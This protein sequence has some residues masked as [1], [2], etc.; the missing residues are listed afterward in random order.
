MQEVLLSRIF[1]LSFLVPDGIIVAPDYS[2]TNT[3]EKTINHQIKEKLRHIWF[4]LGEQKIT[5]GFYRFIYNALTKVKYDIFAPK[6]N[7]YSSTR[8]DHWIVEYIFPGKF[9]GYFLE[10]G[11]THGK[12]DSNC[13]VLEKEYRWQGICIEEK[14]DRFN[15]LIK[16]RPQ[17]ICENAYLIGNSDDYNQVVEVTQSSQIIT[18]NDLLSGYNIPKIIDYASF[19][20]NGQ[21]LEIL[22]SFAFDQYT[23]LA[24]TLHC[25][26]ENWESITELLKSKGYQEVKNNFNKNQPQ[27]RYWLHSHF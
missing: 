5:Q 27:E 9:N 15:T 10:V 7:Y 19:H 22:K 25:S 24:L 2:L 23:F 20:L 1:L 4:F 12:F 13:Y 14:L 17:S 18:L 6:T 11:I 21:E 3:S 8:N 16:N 26:E